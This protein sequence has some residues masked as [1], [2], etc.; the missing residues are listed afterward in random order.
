MEK[1]KLFVLLIL[2]TLL[3]DNA[4]AADEPRAGMMDGG[5]MMSGPAMFVCVLLVLLVFV[6]LILAILALI[7]YLRSDQS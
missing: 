6:V 1:L 4:F 3:A 2:S 5:M 7:K